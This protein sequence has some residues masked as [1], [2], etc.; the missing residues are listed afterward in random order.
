M[1]SSVVSSHWDVS[2][3]HRFCDGQEETVKK[4]VFFKGVDDFD[5]WDR[6]RYPI[7]HNI[8]LVLNPSLLRWTT[9]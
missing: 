6:I 7:F 9:T 5:N 4:G 1:D 8:I 2:K 3:I